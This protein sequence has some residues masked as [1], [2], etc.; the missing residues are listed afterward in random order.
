MLIREDFPTLERPI[1]ANSAN[2]NWG[3]EL[4]FGELEMN[5]EDVISMSERGIRQ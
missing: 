5:W 3:Q 4:I 1:N 2:F